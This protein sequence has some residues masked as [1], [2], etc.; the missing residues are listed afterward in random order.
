VKKII[1]LILVVMMS[2]ALFACGGGEENDENNAA[3]QAKFDEADTLFLEIRGWYEA[4]GYLEGDTAAE[5]EATLDVLKAPMEEM[6][7]VHQDILDAGGYTD[8]D[9]LTAEPAIDATIAELKKII[10]DQAAYDVSAEEGTGLA[11]L[12]EKYNQL[13]DLVMQVSALA[14]QENGWGEIQAFNEELDAVLSILE[15]TK[16]DLDNP[17]TMDEEYMNQVSASF[18]ELIPIWQGYL[19]ELS[20][21]NTAN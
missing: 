13:Y 17:D 21:S 20:K 2:F 14:E 5:V 6:K 11:V 3:I 7:A 1:L 8:E 16:A 9:M 4:G 10:A 19:T 12:G 18:D 15:V